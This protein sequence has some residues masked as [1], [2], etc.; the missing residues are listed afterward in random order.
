MYNSCLKKKEKDFICCIKILEQLPKHIQPQ[1]CK[2]DVKSAL[3]PAG[4][5]LSSI[6]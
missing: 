1:V 2:Q 3:R 5:S 4:D 6:L